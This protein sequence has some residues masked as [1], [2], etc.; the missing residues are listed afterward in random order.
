MLR[1]YAYLLKENKIKFTLK[2][3]LFY[4]KLL[5]ECEWIVNES[6][7]LRKKKLSLNFIVKELR[8]DS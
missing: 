5:I 8:M 4:H 2:N 1:N 6:K 7:F 3:I